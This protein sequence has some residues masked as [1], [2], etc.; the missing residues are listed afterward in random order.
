[1]RLV[2]AGGRVGVANQMWQ[3]CKVRCEDVGG[4]GKRGRKC[5]LEEPKG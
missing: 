1:M 4:A 5:G 3:K 2:R